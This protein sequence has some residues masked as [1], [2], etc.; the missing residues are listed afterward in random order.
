M[1]NLNINKRKGKVYA[2]KFTTLIF[3]R[4]FSGSNTGKESI[5]FS[6]VI[7]NF[8]SLTHL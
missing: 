1:S 2:G 6:N 8:N 7:P 5:L 3:I 4:L